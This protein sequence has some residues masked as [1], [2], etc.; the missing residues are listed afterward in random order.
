M[1]WVLKFGVCKQ[2]QRKQGKDCSSAPRGAL[3][4][5]AKNVGSDL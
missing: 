4:G 3:C 2:G 1:H 5:V